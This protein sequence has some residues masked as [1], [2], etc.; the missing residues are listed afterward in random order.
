MTVVDASALMAIALDEPDGA[1]FHDALLTA[2]TPTISAVNLWEAAVRLS[3]LQ[4]AAG[5]AV[6]QTLLG[7]Y[8][9]QV[10]AVTEQHAWSAVDAF[11]RYGRGTAA[12]LNVGDCFAYALAQAEDA[13]LLFK[14]D[15]FPRTDVRSAL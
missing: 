13:P 15:D 5:V 7:D 8:G 3:R 11:G 2:D 12:D 9:V 1:R 4:G 10:K 14:G 6:M